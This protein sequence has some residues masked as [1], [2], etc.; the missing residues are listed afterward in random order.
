MF[1]VKHKANGSIERF[2]ARLVVKGFTQMYGVNYQETFSPGC[3]NT[4]RILSSCP[5]TQQNHDWELQQIDVKNAFSNGD[6]KEVYIEIPPKFDNEQ[7]QGKVCK[8]NKALYGLKQFPKHGSIYSLELCF[9]LV[10]NKAMLITLS[11]YDITWVR[12][13]F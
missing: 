13:L 3:K 7:A 9:L 10:I 1:T 8:M 11:I 6:L 2:K 12:S 5:I 4:I